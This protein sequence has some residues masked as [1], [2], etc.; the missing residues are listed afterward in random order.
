M[1]GTSLKLGV[2]M[3]GYLLGPIVDNIPVYGHLW[4]L[5]QELQRLSQQSTF[6][7][8][9]DPGVNSLRLTSVAGV[10]SQQA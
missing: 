1:P 2:G 3:P 10:W 5:W 8:L 6:K 7:Y 9:I 4:M